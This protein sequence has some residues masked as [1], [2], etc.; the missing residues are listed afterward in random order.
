MLLGSSIS[1]G[2]VLIVVWQLDWSIFMDA[3]KMLDP[4]WIPAVLMCLFMSILIRS[5]RW[6]VI[7]QRPNEE[8]ADFWRCTCL[9]YLGNMIFPARAGE[10]IRMAA[11][12]Q[13]VK[14]PGGL[15]T[16]SAT[17]DRLIDGLVLA[18]LCMLLIFSGQAVT[19]HP[20]L[21]NVAVIMSTSCLFVL[22][23]L[24]KAHRIEPAI[25]WLFR[26]LPDPWQAQLNK[27]YQS[28]AEV[29]KEGFFR[30]AFP[31]GVTLTMAA[32]LFDFGAYAFL[33]TA[34]GWLT[35]WILALGLVVFVALGSAL[36]SA[37]GYIG[38]HQLAC[39]LAF[40]IYDINNSQAIAYSVTFQLISYLIF[41][42]LGSIA[43]FHYG[44][45]FQDIKRIQ[46]QT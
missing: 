24:W 41:S 6:L 11:L 45:S 20:I 43:I 39:V 38:I 46:G 27:F 2:I 18:I 33:L 10:F 34:F 13:F 19:L 28:A 17:I 40:Q 23:L 37:P 15:A 22:L 44:L 31:L 25:S 4:V 3:F 30:K 35:H 7:T 5:Y 12:S 36:P 1:L 29:I 8:Y 26:K 42:L 14:I 32:Y 9:G 21:L 16:S